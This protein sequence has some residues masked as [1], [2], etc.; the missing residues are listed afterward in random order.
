MTAYY[1]RDS[2]SGKTCQSEAATVAM[3]TKLMQEV[4]AYDVRDSASVRIYQ[5]EAAA[6]MTTCRS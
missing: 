4:T 6:T 2:G 3:Y 5:S 1:V